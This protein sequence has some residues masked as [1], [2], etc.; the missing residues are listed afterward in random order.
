M[1]LTAGR[2]WRTAWK[3]TPWRAPQK[4]AVKLGEW[5]GTATDLLHL[6]EQYADDGIRRADRT[7][8]RGP[9]A[10]RHRLERARP[11]LR[12][13]GIEITHTRATD[14]G[15]DRLITISSTE[16]SAGAHRPNRP[17]QGFEVQ[18]ASDG[19]DGLDG[20]DAP[21]ERPK[22]TNGAAAASRGVD[23]PPGRPS[24]RVRRRKSAPAFTSPEGMGDHRHLI[25]IKFHRKSEGR[26]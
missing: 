26:P 3:R 7:W 25:K 16:P 18:G 4:T 14:R 17:D 12:K 19:S 6:L 11:N 21:F 5:Q 2:R 8:P 22:K 10:L 24:A 1:P 20:L 15:R 13:V 9:E 23:Q